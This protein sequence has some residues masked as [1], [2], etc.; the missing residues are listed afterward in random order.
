[1]FYLCINMYGGGGHVKQ[2]IYHI[3]NFYTL[4]IMTLGELEVPCNQTLI[5]SR[6]TT[7]GSRRLRPISG[8]Y[9]FRTSWNRAGPA[10]QL[11]SLTWGH[12]P[13][14]LRYFLP[15]DHPPQPPSIDSSVCVKQTETPS[16]LFLVPV[17]CP[18]GPDPS[19]RDTCFIFHFTLR[20][21]LH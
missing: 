4:K 19:D 13:R 12:A 6:E 17:G 15:H 20:L 2:N 8:I 7:R 16:P 3:R 1:M 10:A 14:S 21:R 9:L 5:Q 11:T 18:R